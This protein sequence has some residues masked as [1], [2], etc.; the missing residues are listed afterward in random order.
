MVHDVH[1]AFI[2]CPLCA[3]AGNPWTAP[4]QQ[5][6]LRSFRRSPRKTARR[7]FALPARLAFR[8]VLDDEHRHVRFSQHVIA[9]AAENARCV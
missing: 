1:I 7:R 2:K 5:D 8:T 4:V 9:H 6:L 3:G